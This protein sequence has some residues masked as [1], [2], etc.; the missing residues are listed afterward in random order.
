M[1][2]IEALL[3]VQK[4][5]AFVSPHAVQSGSGAGSPVFGIIETLSTAVTNEVNFMKSCKTLA[6]IALLGVFS[7]P[8]ALADKQGLTL[9][10]ES[11][12]N[13]SVALGYYKGG[14]W[15]QTLGKGSW[16]TL[17]KESWWAKGKKSWQTL[18]KGSWQ[19]KGWYTIKRGHCLD[20]PEFYPEAFRN[21]I[22]I[23]AEGDNGSVWNGWNED[24]EYLLCIKNPQKFHIQGY[25]N[26]SARGYK[27][28][29]FR[30]VSFNP[31]KKHHTYSFS[32]G[33]PSKIDSL[34]IGESV[35]VQGWL[36]DELVR[37]VRIDKS[38]NKV[39]V[40]RSK[41]GTAKW[42]SVNEI[43]TR[44]E[45]QLNDAGRIAIGAGILYCLFNPQ[46][47]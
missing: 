23:R 41:D 27:Q 47:C 19:T 20:K 18:G 22:Y 8:D 1:L 45:S 34:D 33:E 37:I 3:R 43:I 36:S 11:K 16:Q 40:L 12:E 15:R 21:P 42:I 29:R 26:C 35:Y 44:E 38:S 17:G 6:F 2:P 13:I 4:I 32:G 30:K 10:N 14:S 5:W 24:G 9:C 7:T 25:K 46:Q 28:A 39:K 31:S